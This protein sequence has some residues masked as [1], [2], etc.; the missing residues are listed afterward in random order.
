MCMEKNS[1]KASGVSIIVPPGIALR[2]LVRGQVGV[3]SEDIGA[4]AR[5]QVALVTFR[6]EYSESAGCFEV[7]AFGVDRADTDIEVSGAFLRT[8]RVHAIAK[9]GILAALPPW[10][11][12]LAQL[13][14]LRD[15]G[16]LR[17]FPDF[18]PSDEEAL[19]LTGLIYRIAEISGENPALAVAESIGLKQR[20]ATNWIQRARAAG[21]MTSTEHGTAVRRVAKVIEPF[22]SA[23]L[24]E[25]WDDYK[26]SH[27]I[28]EDS[29]R[30][31]VEREIAKANEAIAEDRS[32][33]N[34]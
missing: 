5:D 4:L 18:A 29:L 25:D 16:G 12:Q 30:A 17:S 2:P 3:R 24:A 1:V 15:R 6:L 21:Y 19:L 11:L 9:L 7:A 26:A 28:T 20:T 33:G 14:H 34:D 22:W 31:I 13:R 32:H 10:A 27:N 23:Y 8:V